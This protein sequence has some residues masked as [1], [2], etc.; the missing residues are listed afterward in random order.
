LSQGPDADTLANL[1]EGD[2]RRNAFAGQCRS[3]TL[4]L[5]DGVSAASR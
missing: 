3:P 1:A 4:G 5:S 2:S